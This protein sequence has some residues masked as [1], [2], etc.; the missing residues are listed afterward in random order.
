MHD[1]VAKAMGVWLEVHRGKASEILDQLVATYKEK[2]TAPPPTS[3]E[4][5]RVVAV[6]FHDKWEGRVGVAKAMEQ[7]RQFITVH[8]RNTYFM[9][10]A[11]P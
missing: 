11:P 3:D 6:E 10:T 4:F 7:V 8:V 9:H 5:G 2:R 1:A